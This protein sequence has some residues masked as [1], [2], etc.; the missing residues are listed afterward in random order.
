MLVQT[1]GFLVSL[2]SDSAAGV[3]YLE[4]CDRGLPEDCDTQSSSLQSEP[5]L[6]EPSTP[7]QQHS[8]PGDDVWANGRLVG[9]STYGRTEPFGSES[10]KVA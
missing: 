5:V 9:R 2:S 7:D 8:Y 6:D 4:D 3:R 1:L 10:S